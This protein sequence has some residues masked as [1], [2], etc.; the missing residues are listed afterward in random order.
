MMNPLSKILSIKS[1]EI[2]KINLL[3]NR[4]FENIL[5][6]K[7]VIIGT[8]ILTINFYADGLLMSMEH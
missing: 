5:A 1:M 7:N 6:I 8:I 2:L 4:L 3:K